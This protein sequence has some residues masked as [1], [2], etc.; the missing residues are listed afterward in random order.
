MNR[1]KAEAVLAAVEAKHAD[2]IKLSKDWGDVHP[3][4]YP[5]LIPNWWGNR[6]TSERPVPFV[7]AWECNSP[8]NW[9]I[10]WW[11]A[12]DKGLGVVCEPEFSFVLGIHDDGEFEWDR[13]K[14]GG[15][16][17][18]QRLLTQGR[19]PETCWITRVVRY[20]GAVETVY[21][22]SGDPKTGYP[23][24]ASAEY[25]ESHVLSFWED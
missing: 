18:H 21:Y 8:D 3:D 20:N 23:N 9:A 24:K 4:N 2:W 6:R 7:V 15:K 22:R 16:F 25:F 10:N 5:Q 19:K 12:Q 14:R 1:R 13:V 17:V 11:N